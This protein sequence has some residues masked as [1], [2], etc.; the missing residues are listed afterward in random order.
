M[1]L[2][3]VVKKLIKEHL[4]QSPRRTLTGL[5]RAAGLPPSTV[6]AV[7]QGDIQNPS[8]KKL[9]QLLL[10]FMKPEEV[11]EVVKKHTK[12]DV[13]LPVHENKISETQ[14][15]RLGNEFEWSYPDHFVIAL[16]H[17]DGGIA[18]NQISIKFGFP[19]EKRKDALL[20]AGVVRELNNRVIIPKDIH[21]SDIRD[22]LAQ[23]KMHMHH[24]TSDEVEKDGFLQHQT[25]GLTFEGRD[26]AKEAARDFV[27]KILEIRNLHSG[28]D[29]SMILSMVGSFLQKDA[30]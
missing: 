25:A 11:L 5:A 23:A 12:G 17:L 20:E 22:V 24:W 13:W 1:T 30:Q 19:G 14:S 29:C 28:S 9:A 18:Q 8:D 16:A 26:L 6:R 7:Y 15:V 10:A 4:E 21:F 2:L 27:Q 3:E